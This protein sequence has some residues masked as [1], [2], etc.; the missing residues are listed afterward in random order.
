MLAPAPAADLLLQLEN[1]MEEQVKAYLERMQEV[2]K[3]AR[4]LVLVGC[5]FLFQF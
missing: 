5:F 4:K 1:K 2:R 3:I